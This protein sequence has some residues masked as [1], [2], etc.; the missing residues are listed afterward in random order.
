M[1]DRHPRGIFYW[2]QVS[3]CVCKASL[4]L[5][6]SGGMSNLVTWN[7]SLDGL[8]TTNWTVNSR[9]LPGE[10][11]EAELAFCLSPCPGSWRWHSG[12]ADILAVS[13][14]LHLQLLAE[15]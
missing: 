9:A 1:K 13:P 11:P 10:S 12:F 6:L 7:E 3:V 2:P 15:R 14:E 5:L 8:D 4:F